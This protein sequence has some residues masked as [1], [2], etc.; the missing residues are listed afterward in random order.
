MGCRSE[1]VVHTT[2]YINT[3]TRQSSIFVHVFDF[4]TSTIEF[5]TA[6]TTVKVANLLSDIEKRKTEKR[7]RIYL[8]VPY[9][10][11]EEVKRLGAIYDSISRRW[12][13]PE[14]SDHFSFFEPQTI[15]YN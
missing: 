4:T 1:A 3:Y 5:F 8:N 12:Y 13:I 14:G 9:E 15:F 2:W 6:D 7:P 10:Q 11:K